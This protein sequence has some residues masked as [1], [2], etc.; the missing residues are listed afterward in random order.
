MHGPLN[1]K[2]GNDE[3]TDVLM[4]SAPYFC[5]IFIKL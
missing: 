3:I 4:Q 1:V 2:F 5:L